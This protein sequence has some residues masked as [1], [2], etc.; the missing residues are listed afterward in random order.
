MRLSIFKGFKRSR[1]AATAM[2]LAIMFVPI[3]VA[4]SAAVDF[5]R[6]ASARALMQAAVDGAA[7]A[8]V[9]AYQMSENNTNANNV[10]SAT[11]SGTSTQLSNFVSNPSSAVGVYCSNNGTV[12]QCGRGFANTGT[13]S[14]NCPAG[15]PATASEYCVVV[16]ASARLKNSLFAFLVPSEMLSVT[17]V[18]DVGFPPSNIGTGS[19]SSTTIPSASD[20]NNIYI[21]PVPDDASGSPNPAEMAAVNAGCNTSA[22]GLIKY[23]APAFS[24]ASTCN[25]LLVGSSASGAATG[26][27]T[28]N[29]G[30]RLA[31]LFLNL[32]GG[33]SNYALNSTQVTN[34]IY[35]NGTYYPKGLCIS[36]V[37]GYAFCPLNNLYG[38]ISQYGSYVPIIDSLNVY[39]SAYEYLGYPTTH[40]TNH[41]LTPF[42]G[43]PTYFDSNGNV[44]TSGS[45]SY[46]VQAVCPGWTPPSTAA[47]PAATG[48]F[49]FTP[50]KAGG[51]N[52]A[53]D[54]ESVYVFSTYYPDTTF[55]ATTYTPNLFPPPISG[56]TPVTA[57]TSFAPAAST[58]SPWWGFSASNYGYCSLRTVQAT[59]SGSSVKYGI[60]AASYPESILYNNCALLIQDLG[61]NVS[62]LP[63]Y[64]TYTSQPSAFTT[65]A[66]GVP[67][68]TTGNPAG[69]LSMT[70][71]Q[72]S[73]GSYP[74]STTITKSGN[75]YNVVEQP[76]TSGLGNNY[77]PPEDTSHQCYN[78]QANGLTGTA[79]GIDNGTPIDPVEN[80]Q[81]GALLCTPGESYG[82]YWNDMGSSNSVGGADDLGY[83]NAITDFTCP[84]P[85]PT[86]AGG[87]PATIAG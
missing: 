40:V 10:A 58:S 14:G 4:A 26:A 77:N 46:T 6:I 29:A 31:F 55:S 80:P 12:T 72:G 35:V 16:T 23:L 2:A 64:F 28:I 87:G 7:E 27:L 34:E 61:A 5:S 73:K 1:R 18:A 51:G 33:T 20:T 50:V 63:D 78:P 56:C 47:S 25:Y 17:S 39:S 8:G 79:G 76:S 60:S 49:T 68:G 85:P 74:T 13:L 24:S 19:F 86:N 44:T 43:P 62:T 82:L 53:A 42:L 83:W 54:T 70:P 15:W 84:T 38:S 41:A 45:A 52:Y 71:V 9:G 81:D 75:I 22:Y 48:T 57:K 65:N 36:G 69:I 59:G 30:D 37:C 66:S 32:T 67:N 11:F 3:L 21:G